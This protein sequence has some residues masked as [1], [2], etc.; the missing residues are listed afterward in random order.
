LEQLLSERTKQVKVV[1][2][3]PE[4]GLGGAETAA[5]EMACREDLAC[6]FHL[7]SLVGPSLALSRPNI[8]ALGYR[9]YWSP[10]AQVAGLRELLRLEPDVL[11]CS[12]WKTIPVAIAAKALRPSMKLVVFFH[13]SERVH[14]IDR[15]LH[16]MVTRFADEIWT[17]S[18]ATLAEV[19]KGSRLPRTR[20][21]S[22]VLD[23]PPQ[24]TGDRKPRANFVSWSRIHHHKG[25]DRSIELI[26]RLVQRG[27]DARFDLWGPDQ[28]PRADL[29][30]LAKRLQVADRINFHGSFSRTDL[31]ELSAN[32][33]FLLQLSRLEG[34]AMVVVEA[35]QLGLVPVVTPVGEVTRYCR[36]GENALIVDVNDLDAAANKIE[37]LLGDP[38]TYQRMSQ[39]ARSEW[40]GIRLYADDVCAAAAEVAGPQE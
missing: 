3:I 17:D 4:D 38:E 36:D 22:Y 33:S 8:S 19:S 2:L 21:I 6:D 35:M 27:I 37:K 24:V 5:R 25:I 14:G 23:Q 28:G 32:A 34:M 30:R 40:Q 39:A 13:S 29:E 15:V 10:F 16:G 12:L 7:L 9:H 18:N 31:A 1:H 26:S 20:T 11:I